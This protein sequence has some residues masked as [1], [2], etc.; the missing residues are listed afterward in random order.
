MERK[1]GTIYAASPKGWFF[2]CITPQERFF[3]HLS[4]FMADRLPQVGEQ[5]SFDVAPPRQPGQLP[6]AVN[7]KPVSGVK[8]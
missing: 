8:Q 7:V 5:V 3:L 2:I 4:E 1:I 6:C